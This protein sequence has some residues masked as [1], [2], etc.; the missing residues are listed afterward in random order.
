MII[1]MHDKLIAAGRRIEVA[2]TLLR[3]ASSIASSRTFCGTLINI[4]LS[5]KKLGYT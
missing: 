4:S 1:I 3:I 5:E 2:R